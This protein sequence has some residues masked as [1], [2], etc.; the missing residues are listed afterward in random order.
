L[1]HYQRVFVMDI[2]KI[3]EV[4]KAIAQVKDLAPGFYRR[5]GEFGA[6][7]MDM[8]YPEIE[9]RLAVMEAAL[10][11]YDARAALRKAEDRFATLTEPC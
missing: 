6:R 3:D 10:D 1:R 2:E 4:G 9:R 5:I 8:T 11:L 7:F